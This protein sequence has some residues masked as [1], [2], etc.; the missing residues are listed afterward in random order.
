MNN[1]TAKGV[2]VARENL[3]GPLVGHTYCPKENIA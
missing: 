1:I 3:D 2:G